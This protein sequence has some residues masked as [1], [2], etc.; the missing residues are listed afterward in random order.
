MC[1]NDIRTEAKAAKVKLWQIADAL[2][3]QDSCFSRK[4]RKELSPEEK[5][6]I[7]QIISELKAGEAH[8][9]NAHN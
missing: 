2:G 4:L 5:T 8:G 9:E 6:K 3:L 1:N 7:R